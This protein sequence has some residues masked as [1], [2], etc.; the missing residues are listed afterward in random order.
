LP[1]FQIPG[2]VLPALLATFVAFIFSVSLYP[3]YIRWLTA[4]QIGQYIREEGP[5]SHV[6][7]SRT[8]TMGGLCF[9]AGTVL[10]SAL[11]GCLLPKNLPV[12]P[13]VAT[14][15][16]A[17]AAAVCCG[18]LGFADDYGKI[19]SRSNTGISGKIR[20]ACEFGLGLLLGFALNYLQPLTLFIGDFGGS[21]WPRLIQ[22]SEYPGWDLLYRY[23]LVPFIVAGASNA[24][25]LH[26]GMD[27]LAAG[28][29]TIVFASLGF[30]LIALPGGAALAS[31]AFA[32]GGALA[33]FLVYNRYPA[34]IFMGD[35][36]SLF[37]GA[38]MATLVVAGGLTLWFVPL[39]LIY[40]IEALSV[41]S[42]VAYF[43][44]TKPFEPERPMSALRLALF[45]LTH[46]LPGQGKRLW[47]MAPIHHHFEA[48]AA[49]RNVKE[50]QVVFWF[51]LLQLALSSLCLAGFSFA[52]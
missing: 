40:I 8:P 50:W 27:G 33:G 9:I 34:R 39:A 25:N 52:L 31:V 37:T 19:S 3:V 23:L 47:R 36:G 43:K 44:L 20:L 15:C 4:R 18:L 5:A 10:A 17:L 45:K 48:L 51:W 7:K 29:S 49:E 46:R 28:T 11:A 2:P 26:D 16:L 13:A 38:L 32:A 21:A 41:I 1:P 22:I 42:Q 14:A 12:W 30:M 6:A 24:L 35:T